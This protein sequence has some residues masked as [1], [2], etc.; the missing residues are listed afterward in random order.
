MTDAPT[1]S[2]SGITARALL[3]GDRIDTMGLERS[4]VL[5]TQPLAFRTDKGGIVQQFQPFPMGYRA[6]PLSR[7][8]NCDLL[9]ILR[10]ASERCVDGPFGLPGDA[11]YDRQVAPVD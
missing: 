11:R 5:S 4:D 9:A 10:R 8:N 1:L 7:G 2:R 3:L 6:F